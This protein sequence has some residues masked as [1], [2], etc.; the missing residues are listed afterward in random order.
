MSDVMLRVTNVSV[1]FG[2]LRALDNASLFVEEGKIFSLIGPNGA[3]KTTLFNVISGSLS[4]DSGQVEFMGRD[5]TGL[6]PH[7]IC[8]AGISRTFQLKNTFPN[9]SVFDNIMAGMLKD[10]TSREVRHKRVLEILDFLGISN[11]A[12]SIV[13]SITPL[14]SKFV[15]LGRAMATSPKLILLDEL[16]G[17]LLPSETEKIC[18]I[19]EILRDR[20]L[21][22]LQ[23]G[24]EIKPIMR[25]SDRIFVLDQ[26][27][28]VADGS[29]EEVRCNKDVFSCYLE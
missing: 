20:G 14:E 7:E 29:P 8:R 21:T 13:S 22:I 4:A 12:D 15:E 6:K 11:I 25:T 28:N 24:H 18:D 3:G 26:G 23:V 27:R 16:I 17:G 5:I 19:I 9:L 10:Q 1:A 2:G